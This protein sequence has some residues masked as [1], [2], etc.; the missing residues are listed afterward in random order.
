[1]GDFTLNVVPEMLTIDF[2]KKYKVNG[3]PD[4]IYHIP[5]YISAA[6]ESDL[7][8]RVDSSPL[9]KW[10][11]LTNRR[12]QNW[13]GLPHPKGMIME[14][15][16]EWLSPYCDRISNCGIFDGPEGE[17]RRANHVLVNEYMR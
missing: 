11:H 15:L 7:I 6:E 4:S 2:L 14:Q 1:M 10:T 13:G 8:R 9:P 12:L 17:R 5:N 3:A 16:P